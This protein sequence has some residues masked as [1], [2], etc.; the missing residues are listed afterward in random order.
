MSTVIAEKFYTVAEACE[1]LGLTRQ[2]VCALI[3]SGQIEADKAHR[4]LWLI[5]A[6]SLNDFKKVERPPGQH[7][8][9]RKPQVRKR[10]SQNRNL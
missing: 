1:I 4:M 6:K 8:E 2:R 9:F 7:I 5:P 3:K 10:S